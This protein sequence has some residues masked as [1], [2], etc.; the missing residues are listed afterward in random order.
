MLHQAVSRARHV[1]ARQDLAAVHI[2]AHDEIGQAGRPVLVGADVASTYCYL[3][4]AEEHRDAE[5]WGVRLLEWCDQSFAPD[6]TIADFGS[7][8]RAGQ[9]LALPG[10]PCRGDVFP[11]LQTLEQLVTSLENR[12]YQAIAARS[13]LE[14]QQAQSQHRR[15]RSNASV[16]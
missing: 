14:Q 7:G 2:G 11:A 9:E 12:A 4:S 5:T 10:L 13:K 15:G 6:A 8:L 3:L 16:G 1:T